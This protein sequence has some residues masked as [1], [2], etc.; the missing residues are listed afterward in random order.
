MNTADLVTYITW[1][2]YCAIFLAT[3]VHAVREPRRAN[4]N[5]ALFFGL[6]AQV[7]IASVLQL[8]GY[9]SRGFLS[10]A[11]NV[12]LVLSLPYVL[13]RLVDDFARVPPW[14]MC[15]IDVSWLLSCASLLVF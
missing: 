5:I 6:S 13:L 2:V 12:T 10:Q 1:T 14:F 11:I 4:I 15:A 7:I 9:L 3:A 8:L